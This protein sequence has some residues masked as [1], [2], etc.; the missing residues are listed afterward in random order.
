MAPRAAQ[1]VR[2]TLA[3]VAT[4]GTV[5]L[6]LLAASRGGHFAA[7]VVLLGLLGA[8]LLADGVSRRSA[9]VVT[10]GVLGAGVAVI[11]AFATANE[12][13][14]GSAFAGPA[15]LLCAECADLAAELH[16]EQVVELRALLP[17]ALR[18]A[19]LAIG[20]FAVGVACLGAGAIG[21]GDSRVLQVVGAG[22]AAFVALA[23]AGAAARGGGGGGG[24]AA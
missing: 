18:V 5:V 21:A 13:P 4:G 22:A 1:P 20:G 12:A 8:A 9:P 7:G 11:L 14:A 15:L 24:R 17:R 23:L 19:A 16:S 2:L 10:S 6:T 3:S